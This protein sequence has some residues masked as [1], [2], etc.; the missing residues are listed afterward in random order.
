MLEEDK[1]GVGRVKTVEAVCTL[2]VEG[3]CII[4]LVDAFTISALGAIVEVEAD[5]G[6]G[7]NVVVPVLVSDILMVVMPCEEVGS[8]ATR[9]VVF[10]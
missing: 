5:V 1:L 7:S 2:L 10:V 4:R 3:V 8:T 9:V 6:E